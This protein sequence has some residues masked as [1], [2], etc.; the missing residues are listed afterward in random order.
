[1]LGPNHRIAFATLNIHQVAERVRALLSAEH[2][3]IEIRRDYDPSLPELLGDEAQLIQA[4]LN[5]ARNAMQAMEESA[6][7]QPTLTLR[8]RA[9]RQ[10]TLGAER[11]RLVCEIAVID[12]GPGIPRALR[13]TLFYP[14][15]SGRAKGRGLGLS[16]AQAAMHQHQGLIECDSIPGHTEFRLLLPVIKQIPSSPSG[17]IHA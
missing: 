1:M 6:A 12:N 16:I 9:R 10:F 11:H 5:V 17:D 13:D 3:N 8:T 7:A 4:L 2:V 15:V 14:M